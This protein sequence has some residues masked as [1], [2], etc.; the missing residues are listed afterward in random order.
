MNGLPGTGE[1]VTPGTALR[2]AR[3]AAGLSVADV[4]AQMRLAPRQ[5]EALEA[6]RYA[7]LPGAVFARGFLRNYARVLKLDPV[8]LLHALEPALD[9]E[10]PL[11]VRETAGALPVSAR[12][13]HAKPLLVLLGL[14][15]LAVLAASG[16]ELWMR[17]KEMAKKAAEAAKAESLR[18]IQPTATSADKPSPSPPAPTDSMLGAG[19]APQE[20]RSDTET[21]AAAPPETNDRGA[22]TETKPDAGPR[23]AHLRLQFVA[24]SWVEIRDGDGKLVS[25]STERAGSERTLDAKPPVSVVI[26]NARAVR[27]TYNGQPLDVVAHAAGN[28]ARFTLE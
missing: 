16:Y 11:R 1:T 8:P 7:D 13:D 17:Q 6:D 3:E 27:I 10:I 28:V 14:I 5:V 20:P 4:A 2:R 26:G 15:F 9:E 24:D 21:P 22:Q 18:L 19:A 23:M 25:S 12:R